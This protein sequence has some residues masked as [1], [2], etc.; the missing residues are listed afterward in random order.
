MCPSPQVTREE[1]A[2]AATAVGAFGDDNRAGIE[3]TL[4]R[5]SALRSRRGDVVGLTCRVGRAISGHVD[6][7]QDIL[8]GEA[9]D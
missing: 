5:I 9:P 7:V 4:H 2:A 6:M 8:E 3:G 1:L